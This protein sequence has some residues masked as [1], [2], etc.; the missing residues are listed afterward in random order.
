MKV[1]VIVP[2]YNERPNIGALVTV[3][4]EQFQAMPHDMHVLVVDDKSPDGTAEVVQDLQ[5]RYRNVHLLEGEKAG[6]GTAYMR[7]MRYALHG[8]H[9]EVMFE[10][11]ADFSHRP[12]DV[13]RLMA[14][15]DDGAD[16]VIGSRYVKDGSIPDEWGLLRQL[17]SWGGNVVARYVA[18]ISGQGLHRRI[19]RDTKLPVA[20]HH[21]REPKG[22]GLRVSSGIAARRCCGR[23][24][25]SGDSR[26]LHRSKAGTVQTGT[27]RHHR[28]IINA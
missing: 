28:F 25:N 21:A 24:P 16:F 5:T 15:I 19:P 1:V 17:T 10:M 13:R 14:E 2:T 22:T 26:R 4:Q 18:G 11:D 6:L 20:T 12:Q 7:G 23:R 8:L 9:A 27:L 3:L